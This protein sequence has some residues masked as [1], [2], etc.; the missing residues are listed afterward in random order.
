MSPKT[1]DGRETLLKLIAHADVVIDP[2]R[3][4]VLERLGLGADV[5]AKASG[6][7]AILARMTG[8]RREGPWSLAAGHD[9]NYV[10]RGRAAL[11]LTPFSWR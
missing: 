3:P 6:G 1:K 11:A 8:F 10:R 4:G 7:R 5:I 2:F 9:I